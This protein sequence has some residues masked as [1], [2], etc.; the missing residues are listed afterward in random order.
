MDPELTVPFERE[1]RLVPPP[2]YRRLRS[3]SPLARV[4]TPD[5]QQAWLVTSFETAAVVLADARFGVT[6]PGADQ[7]LGNLLQDGSAHVRLRRLVGRAFTPQR[8]A[9]SGPFISAVA[10]RAVE[11]ML[12]GE[13][14]ADVVGQVAARVSIEVI[15]HLL[16]V[17]ADDLDRLR[18]LADTLSVADS[19]GFVL[20][21]DGIVELLAAWEELTSRAAELVAAKRRDLGTDLLS[22]LIAVHDA[23][24]GRLEDDELV[25]LFSTLIA[26]GYRT[27]TTAI[28]LGVL[29]LTSEGELS[30]VREPRRRAEVVEELLRLHAG[31]IGEPFPRF[32]RQDVELAGAAVRAGDVVLVRLEA[33]HRDGGRYADPDEFRPSRTTP[34]MAFGRG[35][36]HC[37]GAALARA[38]LDHTFAALATRAPQLRLHGSPD[39][40]AWVR[41]TET[42]PASIL[43]TW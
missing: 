14:P 10:D 32:A 8:V 9:A 43:V 42:T 5:G 7:D 21:D 11:E 2:E 28:G 30:S 16:G 15:G 4:G 29:R 41:G 23:E 24:D 38:E 27:T 25:A 20:D 33:A 40:I 35:P 17:P 6:P 1:N 3:E 36:H 26:A 18:T 37:L 13:R 31:Q 34:H 12:D 22:E 19:L 39:E